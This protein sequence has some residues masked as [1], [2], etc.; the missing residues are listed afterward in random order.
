MRIPPELRIFKHGWSY[1]LGLL[2]TT[3]LL[4]T[5]YHLDPSTPQSSLRLHN[6]L[7]TAGADERIRR[8]ALGADHH[9]LP[10]KRVGKYHE[11]AER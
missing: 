1:L 5:W 3:A 9:R 10:T 2:I 7:R 6:P 11:D 8:I 4:L